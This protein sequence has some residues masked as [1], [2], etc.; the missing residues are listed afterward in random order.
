MTYKSGEKWMFKMYFEIDEKRM[1]K[2]GINVE[3]KWLE[4]EQIIAEVEDISILKRGYISASSWGLISWVT[5]LLEEL[6]W[7]M[8]YVSCWETIDAGGIDNV[9]EGYRDNGV[10]C[11]YDI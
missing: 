1:Q 4:L 11:C 8:K 3:K 2:N 10:K 5:E 9:I 6:P 7:F